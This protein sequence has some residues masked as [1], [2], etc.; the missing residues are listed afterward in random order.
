MAASP[1][2][3]AELFVAMSRTTTIIGRGLSRSKHPHAEY[4]KH[5]YQ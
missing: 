2:R 3:L 1:A 5:Q 4:Q